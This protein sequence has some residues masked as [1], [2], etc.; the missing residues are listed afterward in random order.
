MSG[1]R[2][3]IEHRN[4]IRLVGRVAAEPSVSVLPS[5]DEVVT[6]RLVVE[7]PPFP[8]GR[9]RRAPVDTLVCSAWGQPM[10]R[11]LRMW[12][13]DDVVE[14]TGALRRRFWRTGDGPRSRYEI[15]V[16]TA[17]RLARGAP[18]ELGTASE[19]SPVASS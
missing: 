12:L 2:R 1:P 11:Q 7:R 4:E 3:V 5:G 9:G 19:A 14:V 16:D 17:V 13:P 18:G 6:A 15:E 10:R 8:A